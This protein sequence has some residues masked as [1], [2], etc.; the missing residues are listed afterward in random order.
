MLNLLARIQT[1]ISELLNNRRLHAYYVIIEPASILVVLVC[2]S[3]RP[4]NIL[5]PIFIS[6]ISQTDKRM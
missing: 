1:L 3:M 5:S 6:S 2:R 4:I